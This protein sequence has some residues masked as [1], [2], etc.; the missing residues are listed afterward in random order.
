MINL[1]K[2]DP[3]SRPT[4]AMALNFPYMKS[5]PKYKKSSSAKV[6]NAIEKMNAFVLS[7][8]KE[9]EFENRKL[10]IDDLRS[11]LL[12]EVLQ[13]N[14]SD[15]KL[16]NYL[17]NSEQRLGNETIP[18]RPDYEKEVI[19]SIN[20]MHESNALV[21]SKVQKETIRP[22][23]VSESENQENINRNKSKF[24]GI[25]CI[26][27]D[28]SVQD[29]QKSEEHKRKRASNNYYDPIV[30]DKK[31]NNIENDLHSRQSNGIISGCIIN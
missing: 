6:N 29:I 10:P 27:G 12:K 25:E 4:A 28:Y 14:K 3:L 24:F 1:L 8:P 5:M 11:E 18:K 26:S 21:N 17:N 23:V 13:Y 15:R 7:S 22:E 9:F 2:Y 31:L 16:K 19:P 30:G 20:E